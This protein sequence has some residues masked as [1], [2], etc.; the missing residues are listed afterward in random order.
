MLLFLGLSVAANFAVV[1][2]IVD[3]AI[4][5]KTADNGAMI[6][7]A[8]G[9]VVK[10]ENTRFTTADYGSSTPADARG[11]IAHQ[12]SRNRPT[13]TAL[14]QPIPVNHLSMRDHDSLLR[15]P[16]GWTAL[17]DTAGDVIRDV[18]TGHQ[19]PN[20]STIEAER[21]RWCL[22][23]GNRQWD[24]NL[25][26]HRPPRLRSGSGSS[27]TP[28]A[29]HTLAW[30]LANRRAPRVAVALRPEDDAH[31]IFAPLDVLFCK[32]ALSRTKRGAA[33]QRGRQEHRIMVLSHPIRD[34]V[35][36]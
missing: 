13:G 33:R 1:L 2:N 15:P 22:R 19:Y 3:G 27:P 21:V 14:D 30:L 11:L 35:V 6:G 36:P 29:W 20:H 18:S 25:L 5:T 7:K 32:A 8:T 31:Q 28:L 17:D 16:R 12:P 24:L 9:E 23:E 4:T 34:P 26:W 10:T